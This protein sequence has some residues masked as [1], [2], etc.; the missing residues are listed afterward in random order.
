MAVLAARFCSFILLISF[1]FSN[2]ANGAAPERVRFASPEAVSQWITQYHDYPRPE[3]VPSA[4]HAMR[5]LGL[6]RDQ[7]KAGFFIGFIAGVLGA[8]QLKAESLI[9]DMFPMPPKDQAII[10]RSIAYSALPD[11]QRRQLLETFSE[12]MPLRR[13][14]IDKFLTGKEKTVWELPLDHNADI[15]DTLWGYYSASGYRE[16]VV[17]I[18]HALKWSERQEDL[19]GFSL[20]KVLDQ[21]NLFK[22][23]PDLERVTIGSLAKWTLAANAERDRDLLDLYRTELN[24]QPKKIVAALKDVISASEEFE[25]ERIRDDAKAAVLAVKRQANSP[26]SSMSNAAYAG[27]VAIST[28][29]VVANVL[30]HPEIGAPCIITG[31]LYTGATKLISRAAQ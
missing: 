17:R 19:D 26:Y 5:Q 11:W 2:V 1:T 20:T 28:A 23:G 15:L 4:V 29:C 18:I 14:L 31:A 30:G 22:E 25:A 16:P 9:A 24:Y 27:S 6:F 3:Q 7:R 21:Y 10:I 8:N 12:R 13:P